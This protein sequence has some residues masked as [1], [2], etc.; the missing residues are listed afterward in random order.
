MSHLG[1]DVDDVLA[2]VERVEVVLERLPLPRDALGQRGS[3]DV[4]DALH[5]LDEPLVAIGSGGSEADATVAH[6]DGGDAV[7][8]RRREERVPGG[9]TV[10]VGVDVDPARRHE[11]AGGVDDASRLTDVVAG[12]CV[13]PDI[14]DRRDHPVVD[15]DVGESAGSAGAVDEKSPTDHEIMHR[16]TVVAA[17]FE[18][19]VK[20][21]P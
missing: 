4:L 15:G 19:T 9:L 5:Q 8:R 17:T 13:D 11:P 10:V 20:R 2:G 1:A 12:F 7:P 16:S 18:F 6:H 3:G 21:V 14:D